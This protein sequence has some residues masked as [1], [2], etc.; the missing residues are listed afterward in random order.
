MHHNLVNPSGA[1]EKEHLCFWRSRV[2]G[3]SFLFQRSLGGRRILDPF[4]TIYVPKETSRG[5]EKEGIFS[6][7]FFCGT[8]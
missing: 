6:T 2:K 3:F 1:G 4:Q 7:A 5:R 8:R